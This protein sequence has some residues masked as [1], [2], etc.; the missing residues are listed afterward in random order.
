MTERN[1][2][3]GFKLPCSYILY[4]LIDEGI[5]RIEGK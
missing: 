5:K 3:K 4:Q 2:T 1:L